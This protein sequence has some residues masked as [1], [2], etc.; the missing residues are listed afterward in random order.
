MSSFMSVPKWD[1]LAAKRPDLGRSGRRLDNG[2][3]RVFPGP[4]RVDKTGQ[5]STCPGH[6]Q[7]GPQPE[8]TGQTGH[9]PYRRGGLSGVRSG[10]GICPPVR[11]HGSHTQSPQALALPMPIAFSL[12]R[13]KALRSASLSLNSAL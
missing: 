6:V 5:M 12:P 3:S 7:G 9:P 2:K 13:M 8:S 1:D 11:F 10:A 4:D